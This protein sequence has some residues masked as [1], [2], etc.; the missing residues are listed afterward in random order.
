MLDTD[1]DACRAVGVGSRSPRL[2]HGVSLSF[3]AKKINKKLRSIHL[4][5]EQMLGVQNY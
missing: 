2:Y 5:Q 3:K 1:V 4:M